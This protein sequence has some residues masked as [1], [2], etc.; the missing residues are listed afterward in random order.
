MSF[1][2]Y[3]RYIIMD[4]LLIFVRACR[5]GNKK[6]VRMLLDRGATPSVRNSVGM[7]PLHL[8]CLFNH[9]D[10]ARVKAVAKNKISVTV[11]SNLEFLYNCFYSLKRYIYIDRS[12]F[13]KDY[14]LYENH[15][16]WNAFIQWCLSKHDTTFI[17]NGKE[18][19]L[20]RWR[21]RDRK[22]KSERWSVGG[23]GCG[24]GHK[25]DCWSSIYEG[26]EVG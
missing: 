20:A 17:L 24:M 4:L 7:T 1:P 9:I 10:I 13:L 15:I 22:R 6:V 16:R 3:P 14:P 23:K 25:L 5:Y 12:K 11:K 8:A 2:C 26:L 19:V 21:E 18:G